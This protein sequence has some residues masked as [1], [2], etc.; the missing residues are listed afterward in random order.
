MTAL[1]IS[2]PQ[3][4]AFDYSSA[5]SDEIIP[6]LDETSTGLDG[7]ECPPAPL[8]DSAQRR[9]KSFHPEHIELGHRARALNPERVEALMELIRTIGLRLPI[10]V[11]MVSKM[12]G[13]GIE[14]DE[15]PVLVAGL[16]RLEA[17]RGSA[18]RQSTA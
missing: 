10:T 13:G 9:L 15:V 14:E 4:V 11:R 12:V 1:E 16:H 7:D 18:S 5:G 8:G 6:A 3:T 17:V 2:K